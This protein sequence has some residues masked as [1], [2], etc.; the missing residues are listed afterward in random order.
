MKVMPGIAPDTWQV[1]IL[2]LPKRFARGSAFGFCGGHPVGRAE[3]ARARSVGC[4]WPGG[5]PEF[6]TLEGHEHVATGGAAG[7]LIPGQWVAQDGGLGAALWRVRDGRLAGT[8]L[9]DP[10]YEN[11][12]ATA[13]G[14]D[15]VVGVGQPR[16]QPGRYARKV[17]L[18]WRGGSAATVIAA[19]GDVA[20][21]A[22][23]GTQVAG[24]VH[25]R[26]TL[27][28]SATAAP[29]DL[30][31]KSSMSEVQSLDG[32]LQ[33]GVAFKGMCARAGTWRGSA[34]TFADLTPPGFETGRAIGGAGGYQVGFVRV[35]DTTKDGG[36]GS[37]NRAVLWQGSADCWL[38]LNAMLPATKYNA[39]VASAIEIQGGT[40]YIC[41][42]AS[43]F[44]IDRLGTPYETHVVPVA[45]PVLWTARL[46]G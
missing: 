37:D 20:L 8:V 14:G 46:A 21:F 23:D 12:W 33:I 16:S 25:G 35:R 17:G 22:T 13:A 27:W 43:R 36:G 31:S 24:S 29:V 15:A 30:S 41:G 1:T 45:H 7:D 3:N 42:E 18:L 38:D 10:A 40:V 2:P 34:A 9:H 11:T 4:W 32:D 19:E 39:S 26:A 6:I 5:Q 44:E 28:P